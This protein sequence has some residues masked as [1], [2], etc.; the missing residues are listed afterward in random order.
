METPEIDILELSRRHEV[1]AVVIDVRDPDEYEA[2]HVPGA[3]LVPLSEVPER[4]GEIPT[5][6]EVLVICKSGGRSRRAAEFLREHGVDA[7]NVAGG[8]VAWTEAGH[9]LVTGNEPR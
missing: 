5:E 3:V 4:R 9:P 6:G 2:G 1:G 7:V 8:T